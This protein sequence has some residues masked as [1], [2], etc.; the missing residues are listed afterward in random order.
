MKTIYLIVLGVVIC[1][2]L[3]VPF[4]MIR[5]RERILADGQLY[6]FKTQ[7]IDPVD[8]FQGRYVR[9]RFEADTIACNADRMVELQRKQPIY[10]VLAT[11]GQGFAYF[12][13]WSNERPADGDFLK[14]RYQYADQD[15]IK[16]SKSYVTNGIR[17]DLP[18][19]R[20]YMDETKAPRAETLARDATRNSNCWANVRILNGKALIE[21]VFAEGIPLREL[22]AKN[23][24]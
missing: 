3:A 19:D 24:E 16:E 1:V 7:P 13:D 10:A 21:D 15:W 8:P 20:Y 14:V 18:F 4:R 9:L 17:I 5:G 6:R 11:D 2:Q 23:E 22:A 12:S